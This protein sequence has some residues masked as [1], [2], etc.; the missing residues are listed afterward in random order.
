MGEGESTGWR[1]GQ[2]KGGSKKP[3]W[4]APVWFSRAGGGEAGKAAGQ[5]GEREPRR[6]TPT[7]HGVKKTPGAESRSSPAP[8]PGLEPLLRVLCWG[9]DHQC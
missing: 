1:Q 3:E 7:W 2:K 9:V 8:G 4:E 5:R 6:Q